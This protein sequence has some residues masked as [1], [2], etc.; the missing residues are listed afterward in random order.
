MFRQRQ[1][2]LTCIAILFILVSL[3][4][5]E[6]HASAQAQQNS[7]T[8][9]VFL[10]RDKNKQFVKT[11]R[12]EDIRILE[13]GVPQEI[14]TFQQQDNLPFSLALLVD[15]S[16]SQ[17]RILPEWK[18]AARDFVDSIMRPGQ[19]AVAVISFTHEIQVEEEMT[20]NIEQVRRTIDAI[21]F[22]PPVGYVGRGQVTSMPNSN[23]LAG[24]TALWDAIWSTSEQLHKVAPA[25]TRRAIILLTDGVDSSSRKKIDDA[26]KSALGAEAVIYAIGIGDE[27]MGGVD[28]DVLRKLA[29]KT[30]GRAFLPKKKA[31]L[32]A[33]FAEIEADIRSQYLVAYMSTGTKPKGSAREIKIELVTPELR[34]QNL[35]IFHTKKVG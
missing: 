19:D 26:I 16:A 4:G 6:L 25:N 11:L 27:I 10:A 23:S 22:V 7:L 9:L 14:I 12:K 13:D 34:K 8:N 33:I 21:E 1:I 35:K 24:S 32:P 20:L 30:G 5:A 31:E 3:G 28:G 18:L 29:E 17:E 15:T 2:A